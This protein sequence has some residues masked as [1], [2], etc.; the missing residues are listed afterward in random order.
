MRF[1]VIGAGGLGGFFGGLLAAGGHEVNFVVRERT[2]R[3]LL[4]GGLTVSGGF[5]AR[6]ERVMATDDARTVGH[7]DVVLVTVKADQLDDIADQLPPLVGPGTIV[8]T[9][10]NGVDA[11]DRIAAVVGREHVAPCVVRIF[12]QRDAPG[13]ISHHGGPGTVTFAG[14]DNVETPVLEACRAA[15]EGVGIP[16]PEPADIWVD[17]WA[18]A[19]FIIPSGLLG[20]LSGRAIGELRTGLREELAACIAE[21]DALARARGVALPPD[22]VD[23]TLAFVDEQ[24]ADVTTSL[25]RDLLEGRPS[26]LDGQAGAMVRL[27]R[28]LRVATPR[29]QLMYAV[30][31]L[32]EREARA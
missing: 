13:R 9:M 19:M 22:A 1:A 3:S 15:F 14:W 12:T 28:E 6:L 30:L 8:L 4:T 32:R 31:S 18:K 27:G 17:L 24:P 16:A 26:E 10:Q 11:P 21:V 20:A 25:Q 23:R 7:V 29:H 5:R 2:L